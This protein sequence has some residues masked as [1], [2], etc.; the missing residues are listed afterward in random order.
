MFQKKKLDNHTHL[1]I[2][3]ATAGYYDA[4]KDKKKTAGY[5][6]LKFEQVKLKLSLLR[7]KLN[8]M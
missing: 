1:K 5:E 4:V 7:K 3:E 6:S 2:C 8:F